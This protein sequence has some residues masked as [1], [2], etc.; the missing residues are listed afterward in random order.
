MMK[1]K[2]KKEKNFGS[3]EDKKFAD[4]EGQDDFEAWNESGGKIAPPGGEAIDCF[5]NRVMEGFDE[6]VS[7]SYHFGK[8]NS[9]EHIAVSV[10]MHGGTIMAVQ[11]ELGICGFYDKMFDNGGSRLIRLDVTED[12]K[13]ELM[14]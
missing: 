11:S 2:G 14:P 6:I 3:F 4:L 1:R 13:Y 8:E 9:K 5:L 12:G 7:K 10:V